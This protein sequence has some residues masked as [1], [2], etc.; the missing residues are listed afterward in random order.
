MLSRF[1]SLLHRQDGNVAVVVAVAMVPVLGM[2]GVTLDYTR[3]S[4]ERVTLQEAADSAA[5]AALLSDGPTD[6]DRIQAATDVLNA[7]ASGLSNVDVSV[8]LAG[9]QATVT[10]S[11]QV[12]TSLMQVLKVNHAPVSVTAT[13]MTAND[14]APV[15]IFALS[16]SGTGIEISGNASVTSSKCALYANSSSAGA[17]AIG[18]SSTVSAAGYCAAGTVSAP[19]SL[20]PAPRDHC[21]T[22]SD[23]YASLK[24]P[25]ASPCVA[26]K[27]NVSVKPKET[28]TL[29]GGVYCG[30]L[31]LKGTAKLDAG[32]YVI[33][34]GALTIDSQ[35]NVTGTGVTFYLV[36]TNATF[37][38]NGGGKIVLKAPNTVGDPYKGM[39][40]IA[41]RDSA[42][43][44]S[45][46]NGNSDTVLVGAIYAPKQQITL[47][48]TGT[49]GQ[50]S[51]FMPIVSNT[52]KITGNNTTVVS[53]DTNEMNT[54]NP[55][56]SMPSS[57]RLAK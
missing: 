49:F 35:A 14:G 11:A 4:Q 13:A 16:Q 40:I 51:P 57:V 20:S 38:I 25:A 1:R 53:L 54:T 36:G 23:P 19:K 48:G 6:S 47:N 31:D 9:T 42:G 15:C 26:S 55:L 34:D 5:L 10:A 24:A 18:G 37:T 52:I 46:L 33:R 2:A 27:T 17:I 21:P 41:D 43:T 39:L 44:L 29:T 7:N 3:I 32:L 30:G 8:K 12:K 45:K 22:Q 56:P 28:V 50:G